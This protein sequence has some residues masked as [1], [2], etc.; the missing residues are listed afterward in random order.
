M[1]FGYFRSDDD[2]HEYLIPEKLITEHDQ[3]VYNIEHTE[4]WS[5]EWYDLLDEYETKYGKYRVEGIKD[6]RIVMP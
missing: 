3:L 4:E 1:K 6:Y 2:G 5:M